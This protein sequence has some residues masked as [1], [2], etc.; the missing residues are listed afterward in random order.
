MSGDDNMRAAFYAIALILPLSALMA[1]RLPW[2]QV[3]SLALVWVAIF[4]GA[5]LVISIGG[6]SFADRWDRLVAMVR[7]DDQQVAG[8]TVRIRMAE[9][10]HFWATARING[11]TRRM[12]IDSG[13]TTTALSVGTAA[14]AGID[15][16]ESGFPTVLNT[17]NGKVA[18]NVATIDTLT[19]GPIVARQLHA[20][21]SPAF[22]DT[23]V[24]GMNFLSRL[25]GWRVEG[26]VLVLTASAP[27][28]S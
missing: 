7:N 19:L 26:K 1:R 8:G 17:A 23:D 28:T 15:R 21:V 24:L 3:A 9:D 25:A 18:A 16:E 12:L 4:G 27:V 20:V 5:A 22:G 10:G 2:R 14:A 6:N 11:V 13:A